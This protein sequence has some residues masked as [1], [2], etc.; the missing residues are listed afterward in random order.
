M[1]TFV[2]LAALTISLVASSIAAERLYAYT[3]A[4]PEEASWVGQQVIFAVVLAMDE[5]PQGSPRFTFPDVPGGILL[6]VSGRPSFDK[7]ENNGIE[8]NTW[9]YDFAFYPQRPGIHTIPPI[10]M[11]ASLPLGDGTYQSFTTS[12]VEFKHSSKTPKGAEALASFISTAK[13]DAT[14]TWD[15]ED[16]KPRVG[17]AIT[18]TISRTADDILGLGFPPL[19]L[20]EIDGVGI[21]PESPEIKD[22]AYRGEISGERIEKVVYTFDREGSVTIPGHVI[23][24]FD[25]ADQQM[26]Y[27]RF[28]ARTFDVAPNP[29]LLNNTETAHASSKSFPWGWLLGIVAA[30]AGLAFISQRFLVPAL[31]LRKKR[32][33]AS[34]SA[35]F[36]RLLGACRDGDAA[37]TSV[38]L[39]EWLR[40][41]Q[42]PSERLLADADDPILSEQITHLNRG[43]Y[44]P[45]KDSSWDPDTFAQAL[46]RARKKLTHRRR[47]QASTHQSLNPLN[48]T[49]Q[50]S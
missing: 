32:Y 40:R 31:T 23:P 4:V 43:L 15:P 16:A 38:A 7:E 29:A 19:G 8:Y 6:E 41:L 28:P 5:R 35:V 36:K 39:R 27:V 30:L 18:R 25:L 50:K 46:V 14:E 47:R 13:F 1:K 3:D 24:W 34:E 48:P 44:A 37:A 21:Y 2:S 42:I 11:R 20:M 49:Y 22:Q 33:A 9:R 26:K 17:D 45:S 12:T 10:G